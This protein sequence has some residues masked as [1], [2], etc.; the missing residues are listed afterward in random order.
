MLHPGLTHGSSHPG[1]RHDLLQGADVVL[2]AQGIALGLYPVQSLGRTDQGVELCQY[3]IGGMHSQLLC[4]GQLHLGLHLGVVHQR[5][6][7]EIHATGVRLM[8][9]C[10]RRAF[11]KNFQ[12]GH[13]VSLDQRGL[14]L[15][16]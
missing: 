1:L 10:G 12:Q 3:R 11:C 6:F 2:G 15:V 4:A 8:R 7:T 13:G 16:Q 9:F 5:E 14:M